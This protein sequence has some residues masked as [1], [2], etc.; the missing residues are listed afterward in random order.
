VDPL[1][2]TG[3]MSEGIRIDDV[4]SRDTVARPNTSGARIL[5]GAAR[6]NT[7]MGRVSGISQSD[8]DGGLGLGGQGSRGG[9]K[10]RVSFEPPG[11]L[12]FSSIAVEGN[13]FEEEAPEALDDVSVGMIVSRETG[14]PRGGGSNSRLV[15]AEGAG[16]PRSSPGTTPRSSSA[17]GTST[18]A[19][20]VESPRRIV[21]S[22]LSAPTRVRESG[23]PPT[24]LV[25]PIPSPSVTRRSGGG[26]VG[27]RG[28]RPL[29][30]G[31]TDSDAQ[32]SSVGRK[33]PELR[34]SNG[35]QLTGSI[36]PSQ[37]GGVIT[38]SKKA[39]QFQPSVSTMPPAAPSP[40][41]SEDA[42]VAN[43]DSDGDRD[44][45]S[46]LSS[47]RVAPATQDISGRWV[48]ALLF[49]LAQAYELMRDHRADDC[50]SLLQSLPR[51]QIQSGWVWEVIGRAHIEKGQYQ[52]AAV[53][54]QTMQR[55][56]PFRLTGLEM[57]STALWH[58]KK[59]KELSALAQQVIGKCGR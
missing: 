56:E 55:V 46:T 8:R 39:L 36:N 35:S 47:E 51:E 19:A 32:S 30:R 34:C 17:G 29:P 31:L 38:R 54:L 49:V 33:G 25:H 7:R 21:K 2:L 50:I 44:A 11:R 27:G 1:G 52:A 28:G 3:E 4:G 58:L 6:R 42:E 20:E 13:L 57:L 40:S 16:S 43:R 45:M 12:S 22:K 41:G 48:H 59:E 9:P 23:T 10:R 53:A 26:R 14:D 15:P 18:R 24:G 37:R 5:R